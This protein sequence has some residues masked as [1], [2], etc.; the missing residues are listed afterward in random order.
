MPEIS[1]IV[2]VY[3]A[4]DYLHACV[5]SIL[6]QT[7]SDFELILVDDGSPDGCGAICDDYAARDSRVR[8]IHQE[9]QGQ[10]AARNHALSIAKGEWVCFVDSDDAVHPQMLER[11]GQAAAESGAAMSMCRMLE[12]PEMPEDFSSPVEVSWE[13]LSMEE[14]SLVA[15]FDAGDYPGWVACAKLIR[16][17]LVQSHLF[18][19]GRVYEDNE[20]VCH[21]I[22]GAKT[23]ASIP[24]S[25][26]FYR[27]NPGSTTQSRFSMKK[28]D[29]LWALE[30]IIRFYSSVGYTTLRER[31][32]TL[33]AEEAAGDYHRVR[34][35]LND[36]KA[37]RDIEKAARRL[38]REIPF[39]KAQF[40][41]MFSAMHPKLTRLYWPLEGAARTLRE[42]GV[43]GLIRKVGKHLRKGENG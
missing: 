2:P 22:Y 10:A 16:R 12:A 14:E 43:S 33:Y 35:E 30:G 26:Y 31:F 25:L 8:V 24:H 11:L 42:D 18:C 17:E 40:E 19:P 5:D 37:A 36:P 4:E 41:T 32:G 27:T 39:T 1:V 34:Y 23:V 38:R 21:W 29:Y 20:A 6:S 3:K 9:N 13:L 28:L 7:V 15:L